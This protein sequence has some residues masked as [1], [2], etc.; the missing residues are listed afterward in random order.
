MFEPN[1]RR[2]S[3]LGEFGG[4][5]HPVSG[6]I[7]RDSDQGRAVWGM[8]QSSTDDSWGYGGIE[9]TKT[10][11]GLEKAY[12]D[13]MAKVGDLAEKGLGGAIYTQTTD[14]EIEINGLLTYDRRV[15]KFDP[16]VLKAAHD[17]VCARANGR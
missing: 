6:H 3:L 10:R 9:D 13:L 5:G 1:G 15:L 16:V 12:L 2:V 4:L 14:V 8:P 7:W 11:E 17:A